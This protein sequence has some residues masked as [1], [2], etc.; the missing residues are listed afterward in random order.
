MIYLTIALM[1]DIDDTR[2]DAHEKDAVLLVLR[3]ELGHGDIHPSLGD[4][5]QRRRI[6]VELSHGLDVGVA[7]CEVNDLLDLTLQD[8]RKEDLE[9]V[10][11]AENVGVGKVVELGVE[12]LDV[13]G[14]ARV[15]ICLIFRVP[16]LYTVSNSQCSDPIVCVV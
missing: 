3:A 6:N 16:V 11:V 15:S 14:A 10:D 9:E 12:L 2:A 5:V 13:V 7:T 4:G 1:A 8:E